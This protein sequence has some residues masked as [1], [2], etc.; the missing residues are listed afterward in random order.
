MLRLVMCRTASVPDMSHAAAA[1]AAACPEHTHSH[2]LQGQEVPLEYIATS[3]PLNSFN[4]FDVSYAG[5][6]T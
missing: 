3:D 4:H 1:A 6:S 5:S 2:S